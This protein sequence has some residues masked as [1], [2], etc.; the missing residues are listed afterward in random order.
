MYYSE[1]LIASCFF[2]LFLGWWIRG[3]FDRFRE[4]KRQPKIVDPIKLFKLFSS[5]N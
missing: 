1:L 5:K 3:E 2:S 4:Q